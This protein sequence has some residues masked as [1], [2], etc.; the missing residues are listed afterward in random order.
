MIKDYVVKNSSILD[1]TSGVLKRGNIFVEDGIIKE[2]SN[3]PD[4]QAEK[5]I[6]ADGMIVTP[7]WVDAHV[8]IYYDDKCI[9]V[10]PQTY[11]IPNGVTYA[12]D[13]GT[14]GAE[15]FEDFYDY[16]RLNTDLKYK[17]YLNIS[18]IGIP[19]LGYELTDMSNIDINLFKSIFNKYKSELMGV[20]VRITDNMCSDPLSALEV[21]SKLSRELNTTCCVHPTRSKLSTETILSY[22]KKG[23]VFTH[24]FA[25]SSSGILDSNGKVKDAVWEAKER[26][27]IF[28]IGHGTNSFSFEVAQSAIEQGFKMDII[29]SDL[30]VGNVDGPVYDLPTTLSKILCL[31][32]EID[33]I[34]RLV[35]VAPTKLLNLE[36]KSLKIEIGQP[37]DFTV[38][39]IEKG[40]YTYIDSARQTITGDERI[41]PMYTCVG[42]KIFTPRKKRQ[43]NQI[44]G[45]EAQKITK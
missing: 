34:L 18:K 19:I 41:I 40:K 27:V 17:S 15:N 38:F 32:I 23:D 7:G 16:V 11:L 3:S 22:M 45:Q 6:D 36:D 33:E 2:V 12:I 8:H 31:G 4:M 29:S 30:H 43:K 44:I 21:V 35:T 26:G 9:G 39:Q 42:N 5:I 14:A 25:L 1:V 37:A 20:K 13:P 24:C 10:D 28:D